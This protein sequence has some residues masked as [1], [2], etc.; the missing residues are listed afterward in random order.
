MVSSTGTFVSCKDYDD[1]IEN[2]QGQINSNKDAIAA[3]QKLVGEGKWVTNISPVEN[4]FTV[5]M[6]DG[7]TTSITGIKIPNVTE[8][9][10][11]RGYVE[12]MPWAKAYTEELA[13]NVYDYF[14]QRRDW[15][16]AN[17]WA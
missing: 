3:L 2:L 12:C 5:T 13:H 1:D 9:T 11:G 10:M 14:D 8:A 7:S 16:N 15:R 4:G 6:S 17:R